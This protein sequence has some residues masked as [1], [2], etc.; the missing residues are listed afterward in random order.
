MKAKMAGI[1]VIW[2]GDGDYKPPDCSRSPNGD[3]KFAIMG[4][5]YPHGNPLI[6]LTNI[7]I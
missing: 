7:I 1:K 3:R 4:I 6:S 2:K 5:R